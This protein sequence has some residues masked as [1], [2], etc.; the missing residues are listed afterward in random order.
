MENKNQAI[1]ITNEG[2]VQMNEQISA[3][4]Q[5]LSQVQE[6]NDKNM[7]F[8]GDKEEQ[9]RVLHVEKEHALLAER[10]ARE[11]QEMA[12]KDRD[13]AAREGKEG[14]E[15]Q[16]LEIQKIRQQLRIAEE[17]VEE[18][19]RNLQELQ[20]QLQRQSTE[21]DGN[22]SVSSANTSPSITPRT[23]DSPNNGGSGNIVPGNHKHSN[24]HHHHHNANTNTN[25][26]TGDIINKHNKHNKHNNHSG[27]G[28][29]SIRD[30]EDADKE[31]MSPPTTYRS[32]PLSAISGTEADKDTSDH[33][34]VDRDRDGL[35]LKEKEKE[36]FMILKVRLILRLMGGGVKG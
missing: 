15:A 8:L 32:E 30:I 10:A 23:S 22:S 18:S 12:Q 29:P 35:N 1:I 27:L 11:G 14:G 2:V 21:N 17:K 16:F 13:N 25:T 33:L 24:H 7:R 26:N 4:Q 34:D 19:D 36:E 28:L 5:Q 9:I 20:L 3:L 6:E 31:M